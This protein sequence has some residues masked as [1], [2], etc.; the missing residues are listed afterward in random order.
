MNPVRMLAK[1]TAQGVKLEGGGGG[2]VLVSETDVAA[3]MGMGSL[4]PFACLVGRAKFADDGQA[5]QRLVRVVERRF[6]RR[7]MDRGWPMQRARGVA[8]LAVF[9]LIWSGTC[10][11]CDGGGWAPRPRPTHARCGACRGTGRKVLGVRDRAAIAGI[12][13]TQFADAWQ[14]RVDDLVW[15]LLEAQQ[16]VISHLWRQFSDDV[17]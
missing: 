3:A 6:A 5:Q 9:E 16:A 13:R 12:G 7:C 17:A 2:S 1:L 14:Q 4:D 11:H 8:E 10:P 15:D